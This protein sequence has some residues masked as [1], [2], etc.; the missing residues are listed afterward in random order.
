MVN[1]K[2]IEELF[3]MNVQL[4]TMVTQQRGDITSGGKEV[5]SQVGFGA[6]YKV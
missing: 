5:T 3:F 1:T 4:Q 2:L 6:L